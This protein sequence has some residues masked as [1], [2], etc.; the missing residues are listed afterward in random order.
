MNY[1]ARLLP[2]EKESTL[3]HALLQSETNTVLSV[4]ASAFPVSPGVADAR[5]VAS[6]STPSP[7]FPATPG[8][9]Q[10]A[11]RVHPPRLQSI[12]VHGTSWL[13]VDV[14]KDG[15]SASWP[16]HALFNS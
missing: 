13:G 3:P 6:S 16:P 7:A 8:R 4:K 9:V 1:P 5:E 2:N 11:L 14:Q 12:L 10:L 15:S